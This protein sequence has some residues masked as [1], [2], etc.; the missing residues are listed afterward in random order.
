MEN[1]Y[2]LVDEYKRPGFRPLSKIQ[3][4]PCF[5]DARVIIMR[6]RQKKLYAVAAELLTTYTT[7]NHYVLSVIDHAAMHAYIFKLRCDG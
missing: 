2:R 3:A 5:P 7:T 1:N 6:R 4:H